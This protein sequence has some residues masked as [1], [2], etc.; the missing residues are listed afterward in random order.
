MNGKGS[1]PRKLSVPYDKYANNWNEIFNRKQLKTS[2]EWCNIKGII[3]IDADGWDRSSP[4]AYE[5]SQNE[6]ITEVEFNKRVSIST[7]YL[8]KKL[9][10]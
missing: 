8:D 10:Q 9:K 2:A 3:V 4:E 7:V 6:K 5:R 1:K